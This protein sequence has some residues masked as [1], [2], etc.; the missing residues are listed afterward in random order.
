VNDLVFNLIRTIHFERFKFS[1]REVLDSKVVPKISETIL[2]KR[3]FRA[4]SQ[5]APLRRYFSLPIQKPINHKLQVKRKIFEQKPIL[6]DQRPNGFQESIFKKEASPEI[7][8]N[9]NTSNKLV[10]TNPL[11]P[12][13]NALSLPPPTIPINLLM[14]PPNYG[15]LNGIIRDPLVEFIECLGPDKPLLVTARGVK[16]Q[17]RISLSK[18]EIRMFFESIS[19]KTNIPLVNGVFRVSWDNLIINAVVSDNLEPKF[20]LKKI[21]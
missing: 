20:V 2:I 13:T 9:S 18:E 21:R 1:Q 7:R 16:Q 15:K 12:K 5:E 14:N 4:S 8:N 10:P 3:G 6:E 19:A 11:P 17:T